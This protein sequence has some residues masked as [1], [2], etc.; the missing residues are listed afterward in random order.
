MKKWWAILL[1]AGMLW[2]S[3]IQAHEH[4]FTFIHN[5]GQWDA[6]ALFKANIGGGSV[7]LEKDGF[8]FH[9]QNQE[10]LER[11]HKMHHGKKTDQPYSGIRNHVFKLQFI[12]SSPNVSATTGHKDSEYHNYYLGNDPSKWA[13]HVGLYYDLTY[14]DLYPGINVNLGSKNGYFKYDYIIAPGA[15]PSV[16][17]WNYTGITPELRD[18]KLFFDTHAGEAIE[19]IPEA[20]QMI[21]GV[22]KI[23][24]C[25][26]VLNNGILSFAFPN[27]YDATQE[28]IIDPTLIFSTFT[29]S[30]ADNWGFTAT[31]D[32]GG[33]MYSGGVVFASGYPTT[34]GAFDTSFNGGDTDMGITKFNAA[35]TTR[36][37]STYVGGSNSEAPHSLIV[38]AADNLHI[39][40]ST[41][42][43]GY[44]T[45]PGCYD[46]SFNGGSNISM[47]GIAYT[48][49]VDIVVT[50]FNP[51]GSALLAST[52]VGGTSNDGANTA[53]TLNYN[54]ADQMRG[55]I[56]LDGSGNVYVASSTN[57]N[58]FPTTPGSMDQ[59]LNGTQ[60]GCAF[61]L[62][63]TLS[64]LLW[65][66]YLGGTSNDAAY[67]IKVAGNGSVY[68][69]GGTVSNNFPTTAGTIHT[70]SNGGSSDGFLVR[71]NASNGANQ[72]STY[73]G[74]N[75]YDQVYAVELDAD[76]DVYIAGQTQGNY[77]VASAAFSNANG[78]Q[79]IHKLN[80]A[81]TTTSYSTK[82]GSGSSSGIDISITAFL[83]DDCENVYV[84]GWGG[85]TNNE[86][87]TNGLPT[88]P[89]AYDA[90]T[91]GSDFYFFVL[92]RNATSQLYGTFFG[93]SAA[94]HVDGG[95][96]R[97]DKRGT[98]YQAVCAACG[99]GNT[100]PTTPG[101]AGPNN[102]SSNCNLGSIKLNMDF[103]GI[104]ATA[105]AAPN[106]IACDPPFNVTFTG[107]TDA[108]NH[109]WNFGDGTGTSTQANP[110][111]TFTD[112]G[113]FDIT[114]VAIDSS[115]CNIA[116]TVML[117]V[118]ILQSET[119]D[120]VFNVDPFDPCIGDTLTV[121]LEFTGSG[122]DSLIW[123]FGDGTIIYNDTAVAHEYTT[124][125]TYIM[126]LTAFDLTCNRTE[127]FSDTVV[128]F[129]TAV[130]ANANASPNIIACDPP[131]NV[132]F[133]ASSAPNHLW[134]FDDINNSTSTLEDPTFTFTDT[135]TYNVMYIAIDSSSCNIADTAM[136][137]VQILQSETFDAV[138]DIGP[139]DPCVGGPLNINL[140]FTGSGAD[141]LIW[142]YGDGNIEYNDT[143]VSHTY[144]VNGTYI[145]TLTA[146]DLT[147]NRTETF[148]DTV[149]YNNTIL[150]ANASSSPNVIACDPPYLVNFNSS[151]T[152][153]NHFWDFDDAAGSTSTLEDPSFTFVDTGTYNIM[154]VAI[155]SSTCN[156]ADT[157]FLSVIIYAPKVFNAS[158]SSTPPQPCADSVF[159]AIQF[160]GTGADSLHWDLGNG[161][162]FEDDTAI[163]YVYT[164]PG[165]YTLTVQAYDQLCNRTQTI[166][167]T[168]QVDGAVVQGNVMVPNVF[169]PNGDGVNDEFIIFYSN[170]PGV[171][172]LET[173][174]EYHV[175][176]YNRWGKKV[177][178]STAGQPHWDGKIDG[179]I[180]DESVYF[181]IV[182]YKRK[183]WD[184]E[185]STKNGH[186]TILRK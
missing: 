23:V 127:T 12:G 160:T 150:T 55:E 106:I 151:T 20:Y 81:L 105:N 168:I 35:G 122:A 79:F 161:I 41:S 14:H 103:T 184:S 153:P 130:N 176:I 67:S 142:N 96:S 149:V 30:T 172:P 114:Y 87:S 6:K 59:T 51:T 164:T 173:L 140:E 154:Y 7:W 61:K 82:F 46:A 49:G 185:P 152:A 175:E 95:T 118:D 183:C 111:Y 117:S 37:F 146:F 47:N 18:G 174:D 134:F 113:H 171:D 86:G 2:S 139:F 99:G 121:N 31:Y 180:A 133:N 136:L 137:T 129:A 39:M 24:K 43:S 36:L 74:T 158:I 89:N 94:E 145:V 5:Q 143:A 60:D 63:S 58:N 54:Y 48:A 119:F 125:G 16:I 56:I 70:A 72:A 57:S 124:N 123:N 179:K 73:I 178:E 102:G 132:T 34:A 93:G 115:T 4:G 17:R 108:V 107:S 50:K 157:S 27:G 33:N 148:V 45:T 40:G 182:T 22:K 98:I 26:Y 128:Y 138:F 110:T 78:A 162:T 21:G 120:A 100:F 9:F 155:D 32:N 44:P 90:S 13:S 170:L 131:Y 88:T 91:D 166:T 84:S 77:P 109:L 80:P 181:Y 101:V 10:D 38:D 28:L 144:N 65:G 169:S 97:F 8:T 104:T 68:V 141:S 83:V 19:Y 15:N 165:T 159:L 11:L 1:G 92:E 52:F 126:T 75:D 186:V 25:E 112:T 66:T 167:Q 147:C 76:N 116:D 62:N 64:T 163:N 135:G 3:E 53:A 71:L 69:G 156:I 42:S 29:G 85:S 177:F